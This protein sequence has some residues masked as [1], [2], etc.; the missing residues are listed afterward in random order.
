MKKEW[1]LSLF[2]LFFTLF[3]VFMVIETFYWFKKKDSWVAKGLQFDS[4]MG[5][6]NIPDLK[7][8]LK[9]KHFTHNS[10]GFRSP[11]PDNN[12]KQVLLIGDSVT[13][14]VGLNDGETIASFLGREALDIQSL[15]LGV[16]GF[17]IDQYYLFLERHLKNLNADYVV[18]IIYTGNDLLDI[19]RADLSGIGK[20]FFLLKGNILVNLNSKLSR[21]NCSPFWSRSWLGSLVGR[22]R[23]VDLFCHRRQMKPTEA[24]RLVKI[25]FRKIHQLSNQYGAKTLFVLSPAL[26]ANKFVHCNFQKPSRVCDKFGKEFQG[27]YELFREILEGTP[28]KLLDFQN[29]ILVKFNGDKNGLDDF[30]NSGGKDIHHL[31]PKGT[32]LMAR[33]IARRIN[34]FSTIKREKQKK[35]NVQ[36][37]VRL[38]GEFIE[39]AHRF[40]LEGKPNLAVHL[41]EKKLHPISVFAVGYFLLGQIYFKMGEI[42]KSIVSFNQLSQ[43]DPDNALAQNLFGLSLVRA[44]RF[45]EALVPL[46]RAIEILPDYPDAYFNLALVFKGLNQNKRAFINLILAQRL[47]LE[48]KNQGMYQLTQ[49]IMSQWED[50][51]GRDQ[52]EYRESLQTGETLVKISKILVLKRRLQESS[53]NIHWHQMLGSVLMEISDFE[54]AILEYKKAIDL[55]PKNALAYNG[56]GYAQIKLGRYKLARSFLKEAIRISPKFFQAHLNLSFV[57]DF[58][59]DRRGTLKHLREA[60]RLAEFFEDGRSF[61]LAEERLTLYFKKYRLTQAVPRLQEPKIS[62]D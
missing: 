58:L 20:P 40:F 41:L 45:K 1:L 33:T 34:L 21:F 43:L 7:Y 25:L 14:G 27:S 9:G 54:G 60:R 28:F 19:A 49:Q 42:D 55:F 56:I 39:R 62:F 46:N 15:N 13:Y 57:L 47:Y 50:I 3:L 52:N 31:S 59:H 18:V 10:K 2:S 26:P 35:E 8:T 12:R 30:Y 36:N 5:W 22:V 24:K 4:E 37:K 38:T 61:Q 17:G 29:E 51:L 48:K 23:L 6:S 53:E 16:N 32:R 11:E 44:K